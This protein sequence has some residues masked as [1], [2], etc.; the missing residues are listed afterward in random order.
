MKSYSYKS[1]ELKVFGIPN[2]EERKSLYR[3]TEDVMEQ[4]PSLKFLGKRPHGARLGFKTD[5]EEFTL[6][7]EFE[8]FTP[9]IGM[10]IFSC[11]SALVYAGDRQDP[12][13]LG[14]CRPANYQTKSFEA[15]F[16]KKNND[17]EDIL[18][19]LPRNEIIANITLDF[20]DN[21]IVTPPTPYKYEK[22]ILYY[23]SSITEGG[24]AYNVN[25][26]YNAIISQHLDVDYINL[27][28]SGNAKGELPIA[29]YIN[30]QAMSIFVYDYD[31]NA[32]TV[33]HLAATHDPFYKRIREAHPT[34]PIIMMTRP[35]I[36]YGIDEKRRREVVLATYRNAID[37]G[38]K[39]VYFIDGEQFFGETDRHLCTADGVHPN[40]LGFYRMAFCIEPLIKE[41]LEKQKMIELEK[42]SDFFAARVDGY[43]EHMKANVEGC[44]EGYEVMATIVPKDARRVLDLGC[45]TGL[46]LDEIFKLLPDI[47]V[48]GIDLTEPMLQ[49]LREKHPHKDMELTCGDYFEVDFG[50]N[51]YDCC[52]SFQTM[53][54][55]P[56]EKKIE[57]YKKIRSCL[58]SGGLYIE[59]DYMV[60]SQSDEDFFFAESAKLRR[61]QNIPDDVFCHYDTPCTI[62]NQI[63]MFKSAGFDKVEQVFRI[64]NTTILVSYT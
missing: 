50:E 34:L 51:R 11:Q 45:G 23:G 36:A 27:G 22:P 59:C 14:M 9:D 58:K 64:G 3:L 28:F 10:S 35:A 5:A 16:H 43:D 33:E 32:P 37:S 12:R 61:E 29:D 56:K 42:M 15:K 24:C 20:P 55:F 49:K 46:E 26:G 39:N 18:I 62:E 19:W 40:D 44:R 47:S 31:H 41:L 38:D 52:I 1:P 25:A 13:Y 53:H 54:H 57:L 2:F 48:T 4:V 60:E 7:I 63:Q 30:K 6:K 21:A 17:L 8:T